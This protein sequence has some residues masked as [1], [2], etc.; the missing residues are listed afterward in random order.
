MLSVSI[1]FWNA[2]SRLGLVVGALQVEDQRHQRLGDEAAAEQAEEALLVGPAAIGVELRLFAFLSL[3][4]H[5]EDLQFFATAHPVAA[6]I[7]LERDAETSAVV[8]EFRRPA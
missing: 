1:S 3:R 7:C 8:T 4:C 6:A 5:D 2:G